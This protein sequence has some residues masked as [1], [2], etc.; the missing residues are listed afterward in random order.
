MLYSGC[1]WWGFKL[2]DL[3]NFKIFIINYIQHRQWNIFQSTSLICSS[4]LTLCTHIPQELS[5][6]CKHLYLVNLWNLI[7]TFHPPNKRMITLVGVAI[8]T[9]I[10]IWSL[11]IYV[12][13][14]VVCY[15]K[16]SRP[17]T[18]HEY[19][20]ALFEVW[21]NCFALPFTHVNLNWI[22]NH[23]VIYVHDFIFV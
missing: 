3:S 22:R 14:I 21:L 13:R 4:A 7:Q 18:M 5:A 11:C 17:F 20:H 23:C 10:D 16:Y 15:S 8:C 12:Y 9:Y 1:C 2:D 19:M 6:W